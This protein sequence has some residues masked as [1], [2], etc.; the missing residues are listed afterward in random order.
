MRGQNHPA[1]SGVKSINLLRGRSVPPF[2]F[3]GEPSLLVPQKKYNPFM[4]KDLKDISSRLI[5][6]YDPDRIILFGSRAEGKH[7]EGSDI[8]LVIVK[9]TEERPLDCEFPS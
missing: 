9:E 6:E 2:M 4:L 3:A 1:P 8:D 5:Q 7:G